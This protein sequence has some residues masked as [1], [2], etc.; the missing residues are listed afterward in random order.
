MPVDLRVAVFG[1]DLIRRR[2]LRLSANARDASE[3][4]QSVVGIL[5][6]AVAENFRT[7]GESGGSRW[8]DLKPETV[9]RK[10]ALG[11][12]IR[13]L[14]ATG[15]LYG[16]LVGPEAATGRARS[17][18]GGRFIPGASDHVE[19]V[20]P[21]RLRWGSTVPYGVYHQSTAPRRVIPYRPPVSLTERNKR[22]ITK[23]LQR[24][25]VG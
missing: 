22:E 8:R 16:S 18:V 5:R 25:M 12:D 4:F 19:E 23:A 14:R 1:E 11:L 17:D 7:R 6:A 2:F 13:I 15:R 20:G 9:R 10:R 24:A 21:D 3:G